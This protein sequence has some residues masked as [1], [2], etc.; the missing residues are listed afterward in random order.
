MLRD[1]SSADIKMQNVVSL[2]CVQGFDEESIKD[3]VYRAI[4]MAGFKPTEETRSVV[5][6][7][8]LRWYWD[9]STG[10]TTDPRVVSAIIGYVRERWNEGAEIKIAESDASAMR[11]KHAFKILGYEKLAEQKSVELVNL[12]MGD[13]IKKKIVVKGHKYVLSLPRILFDSDIFINV[14][15]LKVGPYASGQCLHMTCALK[16]L[17]GCIS[18]PKKIKFHQHLEEVIVGVNKL[19]KPDL[20]VVD[21]VIAL[22]KRP[23]RFGLII[24]GR[25]NL[26]VESVA[27][28]VMGYNPSRIPIICLAYQEGIGD[29]KEARLVGESINEI[30]KRFPKRNR[31]FFKLSWKA[32][33][34]LLR[35][36]TKVSGDVLPTVLENV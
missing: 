31:L 10:E 32:Q 4:D 14:P 27:A 30:E 16:N 11:T 3:A 24:A 7:P 5:I 35:L 33:F 29:F 8:N 17:F 22:G 9:Y 13:V 25:N 21:S 34:L 1:F 23:V 20:T 26:A 36:Y 12:S 15:K 2:V 28:R 19:I 6:K 18:E